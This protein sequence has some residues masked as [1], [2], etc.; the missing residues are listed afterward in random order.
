VLI[1]QRD[2]TISKERGYDGAV[3][4][5]STLVVLAPIAFTLL[6]TYSK[7]L[8]DDDKPY[9]QI[10]VFVIIAAIMAQVIILSRRTPKHKEMEAMALYPLGIQLGTIP[11]DVTMNASNLSDIKLTPQEFLHRETIIDCV[12]IELV[13]SYK[14]QSAVIL[15]TKQRHDEFKNANLHSTFTGNTTTGS[16]EDDDATKSLTQTRRARESINNLI[17]LFSDF[18]MTYVECLRIRSQINNYLKQKDELI[19]SGIG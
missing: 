6:V 19:P 17:H 15:R 5:I 9:N 18:E 7:E 1:R 10:T 2:G 3:N 16:T 13:Y 12:V 11:V 14:V 8:I 4:K